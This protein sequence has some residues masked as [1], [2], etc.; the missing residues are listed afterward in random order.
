MYKPTEIDKAVNKLE[1]SIFSCKT[2]IQLETIQGFVCRLYFSREKLSFIDFEY[3]DS[4]ILEKCKELSGIVIP[5]A[6]TR[7]YLPHQRP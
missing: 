7:H 1:K 3:L 4:K 6:I 2:H 5:E